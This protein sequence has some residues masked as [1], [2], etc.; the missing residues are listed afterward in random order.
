MK[1]S[2]KTKSALR[3]LHERGPLAPWEF[4]EALWDT[5]SWRSRKMVGM[6]G[7]AYL[8]TLERMGLI[9]ACRRLTKAGRAVLEEE[10]A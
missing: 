10:R 5:R 4:A 1:V 9:T 3:I 7:G 2:A 8:N 6:T